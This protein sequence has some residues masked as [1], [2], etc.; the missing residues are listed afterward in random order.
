[1]GE[2]TWQKEKK[3][4]LKKALKKVDDLPEKY[5]GN[6]EVDIKSLPCM[7]K[8]TKEKITANFDADLLEEIK[9]IA[10]ENDISYTALMNDVLREVFLGNKKAS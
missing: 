8:P 1:M 4:S 2:A 5:F 7:T 3:P 6:I 10:K 9:W